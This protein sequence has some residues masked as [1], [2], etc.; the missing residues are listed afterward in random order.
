MMKKILIVLLILTS[1]S[2][3]QNGLL[4]G[5]ADIGP[6]CPVER[7]DQPCKVPPEAYEA[8]KI[9]VYSGKKLVKQVDIDSTGHYKT[10][11][12]PGTYTIDINRAGMDFSKELPAS[13]TIESD[14]TTTLDISIDTG[15]R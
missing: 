1:C 2:P 8:R 5:S 3:A 15:I 10:E 9:M 14:K 12:K 7:P 11:L 13:I 6:I 4:E